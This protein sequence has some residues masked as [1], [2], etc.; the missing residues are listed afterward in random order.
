MKFSND[1]T[2]FEEKTLSSRLLYDGQ[3]IKVYRDDIILP[4]GKTAFREFNRHV[5]AVCVIPVTESREVICVRQYRYAVGEM[6]LEIPAGKLDSKDE[7]P[8]D[9]VR[10]ELREETGAISGKI[11]YLGKYL[12]SPAI[13]DEC[14]HMYL[15]EELTFGETDFDED[16]FLETVKIPLDELFSMVMSGEIKDGKTQIATLRAYEMLKKEN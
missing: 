16:E 13:L 7:D 1:I 6:L 8:Y 4:D 15:A 9:A 5:G 11:T 14:I 10:R 2:N 12:G 3:V